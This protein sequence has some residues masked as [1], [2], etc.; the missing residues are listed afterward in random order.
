MH[1]QGLVRG[2][3]DQATARANLL[4]I[5]AALAQAGVVEEQHLGAGLIQVELD[6]ELD[7]QSIDHGGTEILGIRLNHTV[8]GLVGESTRETILR[9]RNV[10]AAQHLFYVDSWLAGRNVRLADFTVECQAAPDHDAQTNVIRHQGNDITPYRE[11]HVLERMRVTGHVGAS[12]RS[13]NGD[14]FLHL[15]Q[16][17]LIGD[18]SVVAYFSN[19]DGTCKHKTLHVRGGV[20]DGQGVGVGLSSTPRS[21]SRCGPPTTGHGPASGAPRDSPCTSMGS[22]T[23]Q[24]R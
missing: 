16:C 13:N 17:E 21:P 10:G 19:A 12:V 7:R 24:P 23:I 2:D 22:S 6:P 11:T 1:I 3:V 18:S 5:R 14:T 20:I 9:W 8:K 15:E 4:A